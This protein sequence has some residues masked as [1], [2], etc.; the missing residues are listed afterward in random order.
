M[1]ATSQLGQTSARTV[2]VLLQ[3]ERRVGLYIRCVGEDRAA[4]SDFRFG[5]P[6]DRQDDVEPGALAGRAADGDGAAMGADD[7]AHHRQAKPGALARLLGG[8]ERLEETGGRLV[9]HAATV[10]RDRETDPGVVVSFEIDG[11]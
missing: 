9:V 7:A 10:I 1:M 2:L 5:L 6:R 11:D 3:S 8:E 4:S